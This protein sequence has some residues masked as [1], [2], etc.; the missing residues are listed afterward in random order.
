MN[1]AILGAG[2]IIAPAIVRDLAESDEASELRLLDLDLDRAQ[3]VAAG[4]GGGKSTA[5]QVDAR[6]GL[7]DSLAGIEVLVNA[8][9]YRVNLDAMHACLEAR[10]HYMDL[11]G[12]YWMT[13]RQLERH[14]EFERAGLLG[15]LGMGSSPGKTNVMAVRAVRELGETPLRVDAVAGGRDLEPPQGFSIPYALRTLIDE[16]TMPPVAVRGG[17]AMELGPLSDGGP[18][19]FPEPIGEADTIHTL[20]SEV[21]T[22]PDSFGCRE[23]SFRLSLAPELLTRLRELSDASEEE[24]DEAARSALPPSPRTVAVHLIEAAAED[25]RTVR[26]TATTRPMEEWGLG[27]G[28]VSTAAP[29]AA[30]VRLLARET[31]TA[32]GVMPPERCV[33]PDDLF[34][35]LERRGCVFEVEETVAT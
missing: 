1:V 4:H 35:E 2:G 14:A 6:A 32:T 23:S 9:S 28:V 17:R 3:A 22:F 12:L 5:A 30:A 24:I 16:V 21:R 31:L 8:A 19:R 20:H 26:V 29:A 27:G 33:E 34:P 7:A 15:L 10:C 18:V 13:G 11:G 25:G